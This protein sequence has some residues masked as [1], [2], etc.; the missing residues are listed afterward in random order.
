MLSDYPIVAALP[1]S[2]IGRARKFYEETLGLKPDPGAGDE[3]AVFPCADG[4]ALFVYRSSFAG[5]NQATA[6]AW[7]VPDLRSVVDQLR[8]KGVTFH[9]YDLPGLKTENGI[10]VQADGTQAAWF[11][12][13]EGNILALDQPAA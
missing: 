1:A 11:S 3:E 6:A 5:T 2:D 12:D 7:R 10:A 9:E 13:T 4:T 8:S